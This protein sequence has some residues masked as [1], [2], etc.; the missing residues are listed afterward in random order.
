MATRVGKRKR[1]D[2]EVKP[3]KQVNKI[4]GRVFDDKTVAVLVGWI[5][6]K[7]IK[8]LDYPLSS[9]KE[10]VVFR[11]TLRDGSFAAVKI[12]KYET[13]SFKH[14]M[15]Y[16]EGDPRFR[17]RKQRRPL[18]KA[19]A[20]KEY[21]NLMELRRVG[22]RVPEPLAVEENVLM[23][24]FLGVGGVPSAL[25]EDVV[26]ADPVFVFDDVLRQVKLAYCDAKLVHGDLSSFNVIIHGD[27]PFLIDVGQAV[28]LKHPKAGIF[29]EKDLSNLVKYFGKL[30][31]KKDVAQ[32]VSQ[33]KE[34]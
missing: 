10:A 6:K 8:S 17:V 14:M 26:L 13:S 5:N 19:W 3:D 1:P 12:F 31:I 11:A 29:L 7:K 2:R 20:R 32:L 33:V 25:M 21:A 16:I 9:G 23:M 24:E 15:E 27:L 30:G 22:V 28:D 4:A 34:C 18:V